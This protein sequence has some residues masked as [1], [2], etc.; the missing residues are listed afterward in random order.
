MSSFDIP[1]ISFS[2]LSTG[3]DTNAIIAS[4][5]EVRRLPIYLLQSQISDYQNR[6]DKYDSFKTKLKSFETAAENL[7]D[8]DD[9]KAFSTS[10]SEEGILNASASSSATP[11]AYTIEVT[12]L[13]TFEQEASGNF[14]DKDASFGSGTISIDVGGTITDVTIDAGSDT[15]DDIAAA[16]NASDAEVTASVINDGSAT[17][18]RL[19]ITGDNTG[20]DYT[21]DIDA[22]GLSGGTET[23]G[24][25]SELQ[26]ASD[27]HF[28]IN[29]ITMQRSSNQVSDAIEGLSLTLTGSNPGNPVTLSVERDTSAIKTKITDFVAAYNAVITFINN[30]NKFN[31][32]TESGGVLQGDSTL[33]RIQQA[34]QS[35]FI[36]SKWDNDPG[37]PDI[38]VLAQ[39]GIEFENDGTFKTTATELEEAIND[40]FDDVVRLF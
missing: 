8:E 6:I 39:I 28:K 37:A 30:E 34:I 33:L 2:G 14:S 1:S 7:K 40:H 5:V 15:L 36:P 12:D 16:I 20:E 27:A 9:F 32:S 17:P 13:A 24:S 10:L 26:S 22:S 38:Q 35:I 25:F 29:G 18:Y 4:L 31:E 23:L 3:L 21:V 11:G 19:V